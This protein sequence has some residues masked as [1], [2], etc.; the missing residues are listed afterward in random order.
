MMSKI[1]EL[2]EGTRGIYKN[3]HFEVIRQDNCLDCVLESGD[4]GILG[5]CTTTRSDKK[6]M[7]FKKLIIKSNQIGKLN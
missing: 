7:T 5:N 3:I 6:S 1:F 2:R 4:C